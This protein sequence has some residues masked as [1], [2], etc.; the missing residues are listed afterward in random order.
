M[1]TEPLHLEDNI[2]VVSYLVQHYSLAPF[3]K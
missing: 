1:Y 3:S 2:V